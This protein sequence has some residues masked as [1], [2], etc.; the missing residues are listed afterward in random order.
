[1]NYVKKQKQ[2]FDKYYDFSNPG[3][4]SWISGF[5]K[6]NSEFKNKHITPYLQGAPA[7]TYHKQYVRTFPSN[8][9]YAEKIDNKWQIDLVDHSNIKINF[10][11][12]IMHLLLL[13]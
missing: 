13:V 8:K 4:F 1:M 11:L 9:F 3:S 12:K 10:I 6:N 7:Y 2:F 5:R